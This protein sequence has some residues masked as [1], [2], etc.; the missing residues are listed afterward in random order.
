MQWI[1]YRLLYLLAVIVALSPMDGQ[2]RVGAM[3]LWVWR[4]GP[5]QDEKQA[6]ELVDF[7][8]QQG[9]DT[10]LLQIHAQPGVTPLALDYTE[11]TQR[12]LGMASKA[13]LKVEALDGSSAM[14]SPE[15]RIANIER[16][17][18]ILDF[19]AKQPEGQ[20]FSAVHYDIE[21]YTLPQWKEGIPQARQVA[22]EML[23]TFS[24]MRDHLKAR[25]SKMPLKFDIPA[26][27]DTRLDLAIDFAGKTKPISQHIQDI[28]DEI[29]IMSYRRKASGSN[30]VESLAADEIAYAAKTNKKVAVALETIALKAD[31]QISF[32]GV[33]AGEFR[34]TVLSLFKDLGGQPGFGGVYLH[35]YD[36]LREYLPETE[37]LF[38]PAHE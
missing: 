25:N 6:Q 9:F 36:R 10:I 27:F 34:D 21:P 2:A 4:P 23:E 31:P 19:Q 33:P 13:G 7:C 20:G 12:L 16:M 22:R 17:D 30:S 24:L 11:G 15:S 8:K 37:P 29:V 38:P 14:V 32:Y 18:A 3:G 1:I 26:W 5:L 28:S 35:Q